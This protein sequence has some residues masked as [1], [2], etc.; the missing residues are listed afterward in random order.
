MLA[1]RRFPKKAVMVAFLR[2]C[3]LPEEQLPDWERAWERIKV[4]QIT[5]A[6]DS[7]AEQ[8]GPVLESSLGEPQD[9]AATASRP[10]QPV[11]GKP[12]RGRRT[13]WRRVGLLAGPAAAA[14]LLAVV[15]V[16][17]F[18]D[19]GTSPEGVVI[20]DGRAFGKGG[21]SRFTVTVDPANSG[22]RL[23]RRLD[24]G[25]AKQTAL[26]AVDGALAA[27]W[28]PLHGGPHGWREQSVL[29]PSKL[30][31]GRPRLTI[32]NTFVSSELDFN[33]F[34]YF[35]HHK[36]DG[37]WTLADTLDVGPN[38]LG[39]EAAHHYRITNQSWADTHPFTYLK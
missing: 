24:A 33:E 21:S 2:A 25:I 20:D 34:T 6:Q 23:T 8:D 9:G 5:A 39:S 7:G 11:V 14:G 3:R 1:G 16:S 27:V 38:H 26:V 32:T 19:S 30:T 15:G 22:V 35:V 4:S 18:T 37:D 13:A 29:L 31:L 10:A 12:V 17:A 36:V 28:Q